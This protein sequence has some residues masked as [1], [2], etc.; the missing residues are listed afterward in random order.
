[1]KPL[2]GGSCWYLRAAAGLSAKRLI[3]PCGMYMVVTVPLELE[4]HHVGQPVGSVPAVLKADRFRLAVLVL[5]AFKLHRRQ[6]P[7]R[8]HT[9]GEEGGG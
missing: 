4:Q 8:Q 5:L 7:R 3:P 1:M 9:N 2:Y 6:K